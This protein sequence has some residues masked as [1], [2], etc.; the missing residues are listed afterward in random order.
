MRRGEV[1][2]YSRK[3]YDWTA[4]FAPIA[5]AAERLDVREA[6][7][8]GEATVIGATGLP[9]FQA[10]R[11]ELGNP[12]SRRLIYHAFDLLYLNGADLRSR[13]LVL[14]KQALKR[15]LDRAPESLTYVEFLELDGPSVLRAC[16]PPWVGRHRREAA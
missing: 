13:P 10:L 8:D 5:A 4:Q 16:L 7:I 9:D 6:I 3:G 15:I 11:R 14:R 12:H 2:V 1:A